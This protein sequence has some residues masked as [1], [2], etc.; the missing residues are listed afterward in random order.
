MQIE[1]NVIVY[2]LLIVFMAVGSMWY[3]NQQ[4]K[5]ATTH[6]RVEVLKQSGQSA[7]YNLKEKH[8]F[9]DLTKVGAPKSKGDD[10]EVDY[11]SWPINDLCFTEVPFPEGLPPFLRTRIKKIIVSEATW[12]PLTNRGS[13]PIFSP[14]LL[15]NMRREK[16]TELTVKYS[17]SIQDLEDKLHAALTKGL[18]PGTV[19][20]MLGAAV[21]LA[22]L[23]AYGALIAAGILDIEAI[24]EVMP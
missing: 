18:R 6:V 15:A 21:I 8:G 20:F 13:N 10:K 11:M 7:F 23:A 24:K 14:Q 12:E 19:Y 3:R 16:F 22:G 5:I 9:I 1:A 17:E 2:I 4:E